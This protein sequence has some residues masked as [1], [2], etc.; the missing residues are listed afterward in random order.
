M[1]GKLSA[2][3][4][5]GFNEF[6]RNVNLLTAFIVRQQFVNMFVNVQNPCNIRLLRHLLTKLTKKHWKTF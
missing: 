1:C 4:A 6:T 5:T 3:P 2:C